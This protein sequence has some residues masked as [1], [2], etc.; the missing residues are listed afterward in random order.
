MVMLISNGV[1]IGTYIFAMNLGL[2]VSRFLVLH[3]GRLS[4]KK[5]Y[6]EIKG[7]RT[8]YLKTVIVSKKL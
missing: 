2:A 1:F 5:N 8:D 7:F 4:S 3:D 6:N